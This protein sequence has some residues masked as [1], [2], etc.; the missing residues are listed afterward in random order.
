LSNNPENLLEYE[1]RDLASSEEVDEEEDEDILGMQY[2]IFWLLV[3][4]IFISILSDIVVDTVEKAA[5]NLHIPSVFISAIII[6][7]IGNAA[8]HASAIIFAFKNKLNITLGIAVGSSTQIAM[9]VL[10]LLV[11]IGWILNKPMSLNFGTGE[12]FS[13][14]IAVVATTISLKDGVSNWLLGANLIGLY[15]LISTSFWY[16]N[17]EKLS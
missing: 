4:T 15:I 9:M 1:L 10:P 12:S 6:P 3:I 11:I 2:A 5:T 14:L 16:H 17:D 13:F 7:I 8:E